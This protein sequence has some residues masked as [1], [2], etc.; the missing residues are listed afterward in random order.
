MSEHKEF[1]EWLQNEYKNDPDKYKSNNQ[2]IKRIRKPIQ[3][4]PDNKQIRKPIQIRPDNKQIRKPILIRP[5]NKLIRRP[6]KIIKPDNY[7][8]HYFILR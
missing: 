7:E 4:R 3:I 5:D 8:P 6:R 1:Y 2:Q